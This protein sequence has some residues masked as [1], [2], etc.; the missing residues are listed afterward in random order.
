MKKVLY[1]TPHLSTGGLPQYLLTKIKEFSTE[2]EAYVVEWDDITGGIFVV[3]KDQI[4]SIAKGFWTL[5]AEK[6]QIFN[7]IDDLKP[8]VIHFEEIAETFVP[9]DI[10]KRIWDTNREY[11][12]VET[13][14]GSTINSSIVRYLPDHFIFP[15]EYCYNNFNTL[16]VPMSV[17]DIPIT[18]KKREL[19]KIQAKE[20]LGISTCG[21][22]RHILVVGLFTP[23]KNQAEAFELARQYEHNGI[24]FHFVGNQAMN[25][26]DYWQPL[27]EDKPENCFIWGERSD[28][29]VFYQACDIFLFPSKFE[30]NPLVV[31]E[32]LS[33]DLP[34]MMYKLHTYGDK[35]DVYSDVYYMSQ[36]FDENCQIILKVVKDSIHGNKKIDPSKEIAA[37]LTHADT[38]DKKSLLKKS[39]L[40]IKDQGY[41]TIV[42]SHIQVDP[43]IYELADYVI[44]DKENPVIHRDEY[45]KYNSFLVYNLYYP[46]V[47]MVYQMQYNHGYAA[48]KLMKNASAIAGINGYKKIHFV[49]YD[50]IICDEDLLK[51]HSRLLDKND[52]VSYKWGEDPDTVNTGFFSARVDKINKAYD[53]INS[54]EDYCK[55]GKHI[56]EQNVYQ[57]CKRY[58]YKVY[59][60]DIKKL[61]EKNVVNKVGVKVFPVYDI[62]KNGAEDGNSTFVYTFLCKAADDKKYI[63]VYSN[64]LKE[65]AT[66]TLISGDKK[67]TFDIAT[68][69]PYVLSVD[70]KTIEDT[71]TVLI[72]DVEYEVIDDKTQQGNINIKNHNS[73]IKF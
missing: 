70:D 8:D 15:S 12:I 6:D 72:N 43:E 2:V 5:H 33:W 4:K 66:V 59:N 46:T 57:L 56:C 9:D 31:K 11:L 25:F 7:I 20:K 52:I 36:D 32:A 34:V 54:K 17:W 64:D 41:V 18:P 1:I 40:A 55:I 37:I 53:M 35:Y 42:S 61:E 27:I 30:L 62:S 16:G 26:Q 14:H 69:V 67:S 58:G 71:I 23:G 22:C 38:D 68:K 51:E 50:Y 63:C 65:P 3:Q 29:D 28:V 45:E 48:L 47:D 60:M 13:T 73:V 10:L 24:Y 19:T 44:Y 49:N 39:L 21:S